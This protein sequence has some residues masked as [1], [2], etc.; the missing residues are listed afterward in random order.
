MD[1]ATNSESCGS[2]P[3][4]AGFTMTSDEDRVFLYL[5]SSKDMSNWSSSWRATSNE[6]INQ[7]LKWINEREPTS[8]NSPARLREVI[9]SLE[10]KVRRYKLD[11]APL[12]NKDPMLL[13]FDYIGTTLVLPSDSDEV[14]ETDTE[15]AGPSNTKWVKTSSH[16]ASSC[17]SPDSIQPQLYEACHGPYNMGDCTEKLE[18]L[19]FDGEAFFDAIDFFTNDLQRRQVFMKLE[20]RK[21]FIYASRQLSK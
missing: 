10:D 20:D 5:H 4:P 17:M 21:A 15:N 16:A 1:S 9:L 7:V 8:I 3:N 19:E 18:R 13:V 12:N 6:V 14:P 2:S 11:E